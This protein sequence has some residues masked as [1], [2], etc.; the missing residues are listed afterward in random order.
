MGLRNKIRERKKQQTRPGVWG[1]AVVS[2]FVS[3]LYMQREMCNG[4]FHAQLLFTVL[5][6]VVFSV[7]TASVLKGSFLGCRCYS[8]FLGLRRETPTKTV[9]GGST[10][11]LGGQDKQR[12]SEGMIA[13]LNKV[14]ISE[15]W[16]GR[17][18]QFIFIQNKCKLWHSITHC[19]GCLYSRQA[20]VQTVR[21]P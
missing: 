21:M 19:Y 20:V 17:W 2:T 4:A 8:N 5:L 9:P 3:L 7:L 18:P 15:S 10:A 16:N 14:Y 1:L 6:W 12:K 13:A 11:C